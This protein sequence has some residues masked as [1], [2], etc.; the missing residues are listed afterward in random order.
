MKQKI[1]R[2]LH[3]DRIWALLL[4]VF[5]FFPILYHFSMIDYDLHHESFLFKTAY[6]V[7]NGQVLFRETFTQYGALTVYIQALFLK[8]FGNTIAAVNLSACV[9]LCAAYYVIYIIIKKMANTIIAFMGIVVAFLSDYVFKDV[10]HPWSSVYALLALLI[11]VWAWVYFVNTGKQKY[12]AVLGIMAAICFWTRQPVGIVVLLACLICGTI[13]SIFI[14]PIGMKRVGL[15]LGSYMIVHAIFFVILISRNAVEDF[16]IQAIQGMFNFGTTKNADLS[17]S[18]VIANVLACL[19][20]K[21]RLIWS[22]LPLFLLLS[23]AFL[24]VKLII[25]KIK[26]QD[27]KRIVS[28]ASFIVFAVASWHQYFPINDS[29]HVFWAAVPMIACFF[30]V[31]SELFQWL[32]KGNKVKWTLGTIILGMFFMPECVSNVRQGSQKYATQGEKYFNSDYAILNGKYINA[33]Q[34]EFQDNLFKVMKELEEKYPDKN[35][36]NLTRMSEYAYFSKYNF[37]PEFYYCAVMPYDF[38]GNA[39]DYVNKELPIIICYEKDYDYYGY[40]GYEQYA[41]IDGNDSNA[42]WDSGTLGIYVPTGTV[43]RSIL[44]ELKSDTAIERTDQGIVLKGNEV[45]YYGTCYFLKDAFTYEL[46]VD[47]KL[48]EGANCILQIYS[49]WH[50]KLAMENVLTDGVNIVP[51][52]GGLDNAILYITAIGG[53][54]KI[55]EMNLNCNEGK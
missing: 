20:P 28:L 32:A 39:R 23:F 50:S 35:V 49:D 54:V 40:A 53:N 5:I 19:F 4:I 27:S 6:D 33:D 48:E 25:N 13:Y 30:V 24:I 12:I 36:L 22:I 21:E 2:L 18:G 3:D 17:M 15:F 26:K 52:E 31:V 10:F 37:H 14:E 41:S 9:V 46:E 51:V 8:V 43:K 38:Y 55:E 42:Y 45:V 47:V 7:A 11:A 29:R 16:Y 44:P 34:A 1:K